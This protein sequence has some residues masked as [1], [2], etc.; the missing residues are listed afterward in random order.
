M[1]ALIG[2][3][4]Y[5]KVE[6]GLASTSPLATA[7]PALIERICGNKVMRIYAVLARPISVC[8]LF[9][10]ET[11]RFAGQLYACVALLGAGQMNRPCGPPLLALWASIPLL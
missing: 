2:F 11:A 1:S 4:S 9:T 10:T 3:S 8:L 5:D 6:I 7:V